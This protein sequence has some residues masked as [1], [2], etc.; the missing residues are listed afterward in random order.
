[1]SGLIFLYA[2]IV[3]LGGV[4]GYVKARSIPSLVSGLVSGLVLAIAGYVS[5]QSPSIGFAIATVVALGLS[6]VFVLRW[7]RT[8]KVMPAAALA[9]LS[10]LLTIVFAIVWFGIPR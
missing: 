10:G 4:F 6:I 7:R 8:G 9:G 1:M 2:A 3:A 5:L